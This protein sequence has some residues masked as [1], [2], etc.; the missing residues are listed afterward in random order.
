MLKKYLW[1]IW[2]VADKEGVDLDRAADMFRGD[3]R[4]GDWGN[5]G[6]VLDWNALHDAWE[7]L[8]KEGQKEA[9]AAIR[10]LLRPTGAQYQL[11]A[12]AWMS[13]DRERFDRIAEASE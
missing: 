9:N 4:A 5:T 6:L 10:P 1:E 3:L 12:A 13:G 2:T 11:L 8:G 7:A